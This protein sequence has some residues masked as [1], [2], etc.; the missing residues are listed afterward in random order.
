MENQGPYLRS[1]WRVP[2]V[3]VG[4]GPRVGVVCRIRATHLTRRLYCNN[5]LCRERVIAA[6][7]LFVIVRTASTVGFRV[8]SQGRNGTAPTRAGIATGTRRNREGQSIGQASVKPEVLPRRLK[9]AAW[10][11]RPKTGVVNL[12]G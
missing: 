11:T 10:G 5:A 12:R 4:V 3:P 7:R 9:V 6:W 1:V 2:G 8:S